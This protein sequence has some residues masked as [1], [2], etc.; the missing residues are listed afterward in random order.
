MKIIVI[1]TRNSDHCV[2]AFV[3]LCEMETE[4]AIKVFRGTTY[5]PTQDW[6]R[7]LK[8]HRKKLWKERGIEERKKE[9]K[10]GRKKEMDMLRRDR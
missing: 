8:R 2:S 3:R 6:V 5:L 9:R 1:K 10:K 7:I 4:R